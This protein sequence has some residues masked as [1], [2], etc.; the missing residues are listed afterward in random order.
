LV[1]ACRDD[2]RL[3]A[4]VH[5]QFSMFAP[6]LL[7]PRTRSP[8][9]V[10]AA[11]PDL[12]VGYTEGRAEFPKLANEAAK[13]AV[14]QRVYYSRDKLMR[15]V[16][17]A[18]T[19]GWILVYEV[20]DHPELIAQALRR[21][22]IAELLIDT[23]GA[24]HAVQTSTEALAATLKGLSGEVHVLRNSVYDLPPLLPRPKVRRVFYGALNRGQFS[25]DVARALTPTVQAR[26]DI[27]FHVVHDR[28][29][30]DAL[31][32]PRKRF[33]PALDYPEYL[34]AM[35]GSD[36]VLCPLQGAP[37]ELF[38]SDIKFLEAARSGA[39]V[40][41]SPAVYGSTIRS[42]ET[43]LIAAAMDDWN[44]QLARLVD[45]PDLRNRIAGSAWAYVR[46]Q[47]MAGPELL[48]LKH[49]YLSLIERRYELNRA[50]LLR[51]PELQE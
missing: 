51:R 27:A 45:E 39:A 15:L 44:S 50:L 43:G 48:K 34:H 36:V 19:R 49:W 37:L 30:F 5:L 31:A 46:A 8:V 38:K 10:L 2:A 4:R 13:I 21:P 3:G 16:A 25:A 1:T 41:A 23:I 28:A 29:F 24:C 6:T 40:I 47:R 17:H 12:E 14:L 35:E 33:E 11:D 7:H 26:P 32:A 9:A 20:D 22:E 42:G 18:R